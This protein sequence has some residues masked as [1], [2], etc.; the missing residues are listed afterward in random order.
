MYT[1]ISRVAANRKIQKLVQ[2]K[3]IQQ[4]RWSKKKKERKILDQPK[5]GRKE[6]NLKIH[7]IQNKVINTNTSVILLYIN[8]NKPIKYILY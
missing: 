8:V 3:K 2:K 7:K 6:G 5:K 1:I 4:K